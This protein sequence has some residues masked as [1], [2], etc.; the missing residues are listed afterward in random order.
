MADKKLIASA[1]LIAGGAYL[2]WQSSKSKEETK[3][4]EETTTTPQASVALP[5]SET[6]DSTKETTETTTET[7]TSETSVETPTEEL[8]FE[9]W[10]ERVADYVLSSRGYTIDGETWT[11]LSSSETNDLQNA[12]ELKAEADAKAEG[13]ESLT[14]EQRELA[15]KGVKAMFVRYKVSTCLEETITKTDGSKIVEEVQKAAVANQPQKVAYSA[16]VSTLS[17]TYSILTI[18]DANKDT[19]IKSFKAGYSTMQYLVLDKDY[20]LVSF[21]TSNNAEINLSGIKPSD[22]LGSFFNGQRIV[23]VGGRG[24]YYSNVRLSQEGA[25]QHESNSFSNYIY[26]YMGQPCESKQAFYE[27]MYYNGTWFSKSY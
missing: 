27:F 4:T 6:T 2:L 7:T 18:T 19:Y 10:G 3:T 16:S 13:I 24:P 22:S 23:L 9:K 5:T 25:N 20:D 21:E 17:P 12:I 1:T 11:L 26:S 15:L 8:D 14:D